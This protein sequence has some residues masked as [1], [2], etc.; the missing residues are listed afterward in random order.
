MRTKIVYCAF[1]FGMLLLHGA[2]SRASVTIDDFSTFQI[3]SSGGSVE[4]PG[5]LGSQRYAEAYSPTVNISSFVPGQL[6]AYNSDPVNWGTIFLSYDG[7]Y[8]NANSY[9]YNG[10]GDADLTQG[11]INNIFR[12]A[13]TSAHNLGGTLTI[14]VHNIGGFGS[15]LT[16]PLPTSA[17]N[18]DLPFAD[19]QVDSLASHPV[20]FADAGFIQLTL[21]LYP[22]ESYTI[23]SVI[24]TVPEPGTISLIF[25]GGVAVFCW[26]G[27][28]GVRSCFR[29]G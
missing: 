16:V 22:G 15:S 23:D 13:V 5:I 17:G 25:M 11:G 14:S 10:L 1:A 29:R 21:G 12:V 9:Y 19:F 24:T 8:Q 26:R 18:L 28:N 27:R 2:A 7:G 6:V 4:G 20:N 3:T